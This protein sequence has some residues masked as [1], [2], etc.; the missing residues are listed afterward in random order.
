MYAP[1]SNAWCA[2]SSVELR[3]A[4]NTEAIPGMPH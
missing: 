2:A 4:H 1:N 3:T